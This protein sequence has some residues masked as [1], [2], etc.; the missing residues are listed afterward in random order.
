MLL[1]EQNQVVLQKVTDLH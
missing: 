1:V